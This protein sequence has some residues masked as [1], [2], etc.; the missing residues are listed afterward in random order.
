MFDN[1]QF[2]RKCPR[3]ENIIFHTELNNCN[4]AN[5]IGRLCRVCVN[6]GRKCSEESKKKMSLVKLGKPLTEQHSKNI[7]K[8]LTGIKKRPHT[9]E[10]KKRMS[11]AKRPTVTE[12]TKKKLRI[13]AILQHKNN[14]KSFPSVDKGATDYFNKLNETNQYHIIHPN[15]EIKE[16]GY[17]L[18]GYDP[19]THSAFEYDTKSH[20]N[21]KYRDNDFK[22]QSNIITHYENI[23]MPLKHFYRIHQT[24]FGEYYM[25]DV[26]TKNL[27]KEDK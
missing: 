18:D 22:R 7:S 19:V 9:E 23:G 4:Y 6:V 8:S 25:E 3:C 17:F 14:G 10:A 27:T 15:F 20:D 13:S 1:K 26:L 11:L 21:K 2:S 24:V 5:K 16:L 12:E